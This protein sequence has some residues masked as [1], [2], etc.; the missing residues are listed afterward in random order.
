[1]K[2]KNQF[3]SMENVQLWADLHKISFITYSVEVS[4]SNAYFKDY[5]SYPPYNYWEWFVIPSE[6]IFKSSYKI[7]FKPHHLIK[8]IPKKKPLLFCNRTIVPLRI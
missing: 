6:L 4:T 2:E 7:I 3:T 5:P 8:Y 1:M